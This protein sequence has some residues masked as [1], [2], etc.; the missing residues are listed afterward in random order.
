MSYW[1]WLESNLV[2]PNFWFQPLFYAFHGYIA[3]E[4]ALMMLFRPYEAIYFPG[5]AWRLPFTP[6]IFP[7]GR[8]KLSVAIANTITDMLITPQDIQQQTVKLVSEEN[9]YKALDAILASLGEELKDVTRLRS[10]YKY[11]DDLVPDLLQKLTLDS[12]SSLTLGTTETSADKRF[13]SA[14]DRFLTFALPK[15][16]LQ[17]EQ[18][19]WLMDQVFTILLPPHE[20][21]GLLVDLLSDRNIEL[22]DKTVRDQ[23]KGLQGLL[24][25]FV[26]IKKGLHDFRYF[27]I[28]QPERAE[29]FILSL[30]DEA[31]IRER[32]AE[33]LRHF[34]PH[35]LSNETL[36]IIREALIKTLKRL[37]IENKTELSQMITHLSSEA[38][39]SL[40]HH[41]LSLDYSQWVEKSLPGL[42]K[43]IAKFIHTYLHRQLEN[44]LKQALPAMSMNTVIVEKIDRFSAKEL[45]QLIQKICHRELRTLAYLG[46]FLGLW[47]GLLSNLIAYWVHPITP[48]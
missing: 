43:D 4:M 11:I 39:H 9:I 19:Q 18:A 34:S 48:P 44:L 2:E 20:I 17:T 40:T 14:L 13:H 37:L 7:R 12:L 42:K 8:H 36:E 21:R 46:A 31:E 41:L 26:D 5:T 47:L 35:Q 23:I 25:A 22:I 1:Q 33:Q 15:L 30:I 38:T 3:T 16:Q 29:Q 10:L 27:I 28:D 45:E 24:L 6:G 32:L